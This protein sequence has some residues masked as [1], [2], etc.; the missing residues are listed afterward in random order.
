MIRTY[1]FLSPLLFHQAVNAVI[2]GPVH[3][4]V[5]LKTVAVGTFRNKTCE[6]LQMKE[7]TVWESWAA[8]GW[9]EL[10]VFISLGVLFSLFLFVGFIFVP[11]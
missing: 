3:V 4:A 7:L 5:L 8:V 2:L 10:K 6:G 11:V 1:R 9:P